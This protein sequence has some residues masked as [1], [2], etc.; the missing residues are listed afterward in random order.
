MSEQND[1]SLEHKRIGLAR[2]PLKRGLVAFTFEA[3][4]APD[5]ADVLILRHSDGSTMPATYAGSATPEMV[6][7]GESP[8]MLID[9]YVIDPSGAPLAM[10]VVDMFEADGDAS[11]G[12]DWGVM[13]LPQ[14]PLTP[15]LKASDRRGADDVEAAFASKGFAAYL[16]DRH[17]SIGAGDE[18]TVSGRAGTIISVDRRKRVADIEFRDDGETM[19]VDLHEIDELESNE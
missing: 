9:E 3:N 19:S 2:T 7:E 11:S 18:A 1:I 17:L 15:V 13:G 12:H 5:R 10:S 4:T 8:C 16:A 6:T 14:G